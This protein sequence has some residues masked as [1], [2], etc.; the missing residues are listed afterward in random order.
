MKFCITAIMLAAMALALPA[1]ITRPFPPIKLGSPRGS[2]IIHAV[3]VTNSSL[4]VENKARDKFVIPIVKK[5]G[6]GDEGKGAQELEDE[7]RELEWKLREAAREADEQEKVVEE[8]GDDG[9]GVGDDGDLVERD[10]DGKKKN[11]CEETYSK[12]NPTLLSYRRA[13]SD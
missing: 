5:T 1:N 11:P 2:T 8:D 9:D 3:N 4:V 7:D 10:S 6:G 12:S 13:L